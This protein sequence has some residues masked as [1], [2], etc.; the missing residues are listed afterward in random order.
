MTLLPRGHGGVWVVI[1]GGDR[2][3]IAAGI[4]RVGPGMLLNGLH[5]ETHPA[6]HVSSAEVGKSCV[7]RSRFHSWTGVS[8]RSWHGYL[9]MIDL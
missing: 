1:T 7:R 3:G 9:N 4:W 6:Q 5:M 2:E 8:T